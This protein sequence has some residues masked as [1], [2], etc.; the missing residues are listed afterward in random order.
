MQNQAATLTDMLNS[1]EISFQEYQRL[2][3]DSM[4]QD[5]AGAWWM[6]DA[7]N[8]Q[9]YRHDSANNEWVIDYPAAL[10]RV[11]GISTSAGRQAI[12]RR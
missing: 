8:E 9:W 7:E 3:Y 12:I 6:I 1:E 11:G 10:R 5:E 2:L 4:V